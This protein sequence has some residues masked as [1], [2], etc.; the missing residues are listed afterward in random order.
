MNTFTA[1]YSARNTIEDVEGLGNLVWHDTLIID[2]KLA[3]HI[4]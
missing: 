3:L 1:I 2:H 4:I